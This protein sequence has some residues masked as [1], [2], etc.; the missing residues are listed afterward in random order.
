MTPHLKKSINQAYLENGTYEQIVTH[1]EKEI[2]LNGL[3]AP[4]ELQLNTVSH[5]T[6]NTNADRPKLTCLHCKEPGH[7]RNQCRLLEKQREQTENTQNKP[8]SK[9]SDAINSNTNSNLNNINN[10][11][12]NYKTVTELKG[13]QKLSIYPVRHVTNRTTPQRDNMLEPVQQTG[14]FP[15]TAN[16]EDR[17][18]IIN[19]THR[20][21]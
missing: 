3:E 8:G 21:V 11:H 2:E 4:D 15:G 9:N 12:N 17:V 6:R 20:T 19:S 14:H 10:N 13:S 18:D 16:H 1:L 5:N 7:D